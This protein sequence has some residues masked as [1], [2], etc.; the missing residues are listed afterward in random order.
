MKCIRCKGY[1]VQEQ[2]FTSE[3]SIPVLRCLCCG[4]LI[5]HVIMANRNRSEIFHVRKYKSRKNRLNSAP[6]I[7]KLLLNE[8][9]FDRK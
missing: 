1:T 3:G 8:S 6:L 7:V 2:V 5:D 9:L 4:E